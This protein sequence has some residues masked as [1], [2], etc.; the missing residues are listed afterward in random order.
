MSFVESTNKSKAPTIHFRQKQNI[1][2]LSK[3]TEDRLRKKYFS[4]NS[5]DKSYLPLKVVH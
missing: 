3:I 5:H 2:V 4:M 1:A